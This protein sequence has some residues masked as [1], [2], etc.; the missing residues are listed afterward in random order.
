MLGFSGNASNATAYWKGGDAITLQK[1]Q[2]AVQTMPS[3]FYS[4]KPPSKFSSSEPSTTSG[5]SIS[6]STSKQQTTSP[7]LQLTKTPNKFEPQ[8]HNCEVL[9]LPGNTENNLIASRLQLSEFNL[10]MTKVSYYITL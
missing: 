5:S 1:A 9:C 3:R 8:N 6:K 10:Y 7:P 4:K 2:L